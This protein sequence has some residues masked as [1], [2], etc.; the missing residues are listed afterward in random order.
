MRE[1]LGSFGRPGLADREACGRPTL[2]GQRAG[3]ELDC[4][5]APRLDCGRAPGAL[6]RMM[7]DCV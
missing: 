4:G 6:A 1:H 7:P 3:A 2:A 5:R